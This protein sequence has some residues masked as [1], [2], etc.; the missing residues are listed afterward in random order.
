MKNEVRDGDTRGLRFFEL[1]LSRESEGVVE[2]EAQIIAVEHKTPPFG[3][4]TGFGGIICAHIT[5]HTH[6]SHNAAPLRERDSDTGL[7][8]NLPCNCGLTVFTIVACTTGTNANSPIDKQA[9]YSALKER[10]TV[11]RS[12]LKQI[13]SDLLTVVIIRPTD[14]GTDGSPVAQIITDFGEYTHSSHVV[15]TI[16]PCAD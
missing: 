7:Q 5:E 12:D 3:S 2:T 1:V 16:S 10:I 15:S 13:G 14:S 4:I 8:T 6:M 11:V 9:D